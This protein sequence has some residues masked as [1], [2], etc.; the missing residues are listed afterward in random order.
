[1]MVQSKNEKNS[2]HTE[3]CQGDLFYKFCKQFTT[4]EMAFLKR[5]IFL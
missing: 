5:E 4:S 1:M 2:S 3:S